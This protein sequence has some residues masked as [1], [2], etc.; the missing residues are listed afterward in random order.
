VSLPRRFRHPKLGNF[1]VVYVDKGRNVHVVNTKGEKRAI[2]EK[3]GAFLKDKKKP[4]GAK[5]TYTPP[6]PSGK[7][8]WYQPLIPGTERMNFPEK[9]QKNAFGVVHKVLVETKEGW[10]VQSKKGKALSK[11]ATREQAL[12]RLRQIEYYKKQKG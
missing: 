11:P 6:P 7:Q 4:E 8:E 12:K 2:P 5:E 1:R 10:I 9:F 3:E